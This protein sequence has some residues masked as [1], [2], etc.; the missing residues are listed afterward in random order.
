MD[1]NFSWVLSV[2]SYNT[3]WN[4]CCLVIMEILKH[5]LVGTSQE[6]A[7]VITVNI[8]LTVFCWLL[9]VIEL[10]GDASHKVMRQL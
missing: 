3:N 7:I 9:S 2:E 5:G 4:L 10:S 6:R 1:K 8:H